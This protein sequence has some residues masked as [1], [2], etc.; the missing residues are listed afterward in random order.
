MIANLK[1]AHVAHLAIVKLA[2]AK[3]LIGAGVV[4]GGAA[5]GLVATELLAPDYMD[6]ANA[7]INQAVDAEAGRTSPMLRATVLPT[8]DHADKGEPAASIPAHEILVERSAALIWSADSS[9]LSSDI[10]QVFITAKRMSPAQKL[11]YD[12]E[13]RFSLLASR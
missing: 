10:P 5:T 7:F 11:A 2:A 9:P 4:F 3:A 13:R 1:I 12:V 6:A 8:G